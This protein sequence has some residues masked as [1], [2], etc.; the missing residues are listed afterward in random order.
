MP[1]RS[2]EFAA[3]GL[4]SI[5]KESQ[6]T[7]VNAE[8][9]ALRDEIGRYQDHQRQLANAVFLVIGGSLTLLGPVTAKVAG[10]DNAAVAGP[11]LLLFTPPLY[12]LLAFLYA[13][14]AV[15]IIRLAHYIHNH[16]RPVAS[17]IAGIEV[18]SWEKYKNETRVVSRRIAYLLDKMRWMVFIA[19]L[20]ATTL[21][22]IFKLGHGSLEYQIVAAVDGAISCA[23]AVGA[24]ILTEETSGVVGESSKRRSGRM[25]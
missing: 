20:I 5:N 16:L 19:P 10:D 21:F 14:R 6:A 1:A 3:Q 23:G 11:I 12:C 22:A 8:Y 24:A 7:I 17:S 15:R 4:Q 18:W 2:K 13:D 9:T 25:A